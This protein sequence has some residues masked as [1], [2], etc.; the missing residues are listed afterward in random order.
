MSLDDLQRGARRIADRL[1]SRVGPRR[2]RIGGMALVGVLGLGAG[3]AWGAWSHV[4]DDCPSIAQIYAFEP[5]EGSRIFA[6]DGSMLAELAV[7]R[8][9]A[10]PYSALP[11]HLPQAFVAIEDRR[12][13]R[14][15][16]V[17]FLRTVRAALE[18]L[19]LGYDAA[20]ASTVTQQLAGNMFE[21]SVNRRVISIR[22]K[23][24]EMRVAF[25]LER[26]YT[27]REILEAYVN[28][29][30]FG[31]GHYGV[32]SAAS[33]YFGVDA[34]DLNLPQAAMLAALP[35]APQT[36]SPIHHPDRA[37]QRRNLV[38][39]LMADQGIIP[40][41][42]AERA[43]AYPLGLDR[44]ERGRTP[45]PYFVEWVRRLL[46][47][48]YGDEIYRAGYRVY[49]TLSPELQT[50]ADSALHAQLRWVEERSSF[51][52]PRYDSLL[53]AGEGIDDG[54]RT[55]YLQGAF[56]A[57]DPRTGDVLALLGGR[58]H[59]HSEFNRATQALR[60]PG[61][62]FKPF[63]YTAAVA[64][65]IPASEVIRDTPTEIPLPDS[66][67]YSPKNFGDVFHG[68]V[69]LRE[70]LYRSINVVAVKVGQRVGEES[71]AQMA[72]RMGI[73]TPVPRVP[74]V[75]IGAASVIPIEVAEAYTAFAN[76]GV[77]V[78][79]R[80]ILRVESADGELLWENP[81]SREEV[82]DAETAWLMVDI[83]RDVVDAPRGTGAVVRRL[84]LPR[85]VPAAGKTGTTNDATD[86]WF[87]GFTPELV[88]TSW[89]GFDEPRRL[90]VNAQGGVDAAPINA[91]VLKR[92]YRDRPAPA[93][94]PRPPGIVEEQVDRMTG[95]RQTP[96]CP[97]DS[98]YVEHFLPGTQPQE[99]CN[100]HG[101]WGAGELEAS[102]VDGS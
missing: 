45:A 34:R 92:F 44:G 36:Y 60:Q 1:R 55:P 9:T 87:V 39:D 8:R 50:A 91:E 86:A 5:K 67:L 90:H 27:K 21:E 97:A 32:Q 100:L 102:E 41:A 51:R 38:L 101:P 75:A 98:V 49:T 6:A 12:F 31:D 99:L 25:A 56:I 29:I 53:T 26:A 79:P 22:R 80:A 48:R 18:F 81:V 37:L 13:W 54:A 47:D 89:V 78:E 96:W 71:V 68:P 73:S 23:L 43:K 57:L 94:W 10:I 66:T 58:D 24:K 35:K 69:T 76:L 59:E 63:V 85:E 28:Q 93:P 30:N 83:L 64:S 40:R 62:V 7:E 88:T 74:S 3:L 19:V 2:L 33:Y 17:D 16:G 11:P 95:L 42:R 77:R 65:G 46:K 61:S 84:G 72:R 82:L 52:G 4:C 20:G 14:H 15:P 70:A